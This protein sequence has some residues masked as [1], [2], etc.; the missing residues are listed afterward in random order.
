MDCFFAVST[1]I[2]FCIM[3][4][5]FEFIIDDMHSFRQAQWLPSSKILHQILSLFVQDRPRRTFFVD[6][7]V[8]KSVRSI[9]II[10][11][12]SCIKWRYTC[13]FLSE[14]DCLTMTYTCPFTQFRMRTEFYV[15]EFDKL[16]DSAIPVVSLSTLM[17]LFL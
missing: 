8:S 4:W 5:A 1:G 14:Y 2:D 6:Q 11:L 13:L 7:R 15:Y 16:F 17:M 9:S 12:D 10:Y 3:Y